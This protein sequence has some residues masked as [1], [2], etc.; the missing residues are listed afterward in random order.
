MGSDANGTDLSRNT[1]ESMS[2]DA[3]PILP[4]KKISHLSRAG[5]Q[6][7]MEFRQSAQLLTKSN[8]LFSKAGCP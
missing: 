2:Y 3:A 6:I 1:Y 8:A 4:R 7:G 5:A